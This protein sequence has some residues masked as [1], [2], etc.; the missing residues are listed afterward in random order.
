MAAAAEVH[1]SG[2]P[3]S[4]DPTRQILDPSSNPVYSFG[5]SDFL[6]R[7]YRF[8]LDPNRPQCKAFREG[9]CPLGSACPDKHHTFSAFN[10]LVC[11]HWLRGLCKK[12]DACEF[13]HEYNLFAFQSAK[14]ISDV[15]GSMLT[16]ARHHRRKQSECNQY[17]RYQYC[18]SGDECLFLHIDPESK[19]EPCPHYEKGMCILGP[20]CAKKHIR[21][22][23][24]RFWMAGFCPY[25]RKCQEGAHPQWPKHLSPP[26]K[27]RKPDPEKVEADRQKLRELGEREEEEGGR[28]QNNR[29]ERGGRGRGRGSR[30]RRGGYDR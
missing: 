30:G 26:E 24:C 9:H 10:S 17:N 11:K 1:H 7:E 22:T 28:F 6:K 8:G 5:F 29:R 20:L 23:M 19:R 14:G 4:I 16:F 25:G 27:R 21:K 18:S 3:S 12:G 15:H 2:R 13:L